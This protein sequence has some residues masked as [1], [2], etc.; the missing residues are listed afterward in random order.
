MTSIEIPPLGP[1]EATVTVPGSKSLT[2]RALLVA[3]LAEGESV[4]TGCLFS[5]DTRYMLGA[6]KTLGVE[7]HADEPAA[8]IRVRGCNGRFP[9]EGVGLYVGNAG[10][11]MRFLTA[12]CAAC[13][14]GIII[15]GNARMRERPIRELTDALRPLGAEIDCPTGCPPV[16]VVGGGLKAGRCE[17]RDPQSSQYVSAVLMAAPYCM[18]PA[19]IAVGGTLVS[20]PYVEMTV[21]LMADF[22]IAVERMGNSFRVAGPARYAARDRYPVE[23]D[24]SSASYPLAIAAVTGGKIRVRGLGTDSKQGDAHFVDVLEKMGCTVGRGTDFLEVRGGPLRGIDVDLADMPDMAQTLA[25]VA[26]FAEGPTTIRGVANLRIKETDRIAAL[27]NELTKL[28][29]AVTVLPDGLTVRPPTGG[30]AGIRPAEIDTYDDHRMAMSFAVIG[31]GAPGVVIR[32]PGCTSK[33][34]PEFFDWLAGLRGGRGGSH[35]VGSG[36]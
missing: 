12:A 22:G 14:R 6:L 21:A 28:G 18:G 33:T 7:C 8:T 16:R 5:D 34:W 35:P 11:A 10:T 15:D 13:G 23:P 32:D 27:E 1:L 36:L 31:C 4:L 19:D 3:A 17:F 20:E 24:A 2:N 30:R 25:A 26:M 29:A 9:N